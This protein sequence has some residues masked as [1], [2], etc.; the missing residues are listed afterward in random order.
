MQAIHSKN[1]VTIKNQG[2]Q[3][4]NGSPYPNN[5]YPI[6]KLYSFA[7]V[8]YRCIIASLLPN[9]GTCGRYFIYFLLCVSMVK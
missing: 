9:R 7:Q 1:Q 4:G 6:F 3:L 8:F 5:L 2:G